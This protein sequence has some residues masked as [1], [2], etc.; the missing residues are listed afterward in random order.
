VVGDE[1]PD[2]RL[3][4]HDQNVSVACHRRD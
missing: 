1:M 3:V 4:L 2:I